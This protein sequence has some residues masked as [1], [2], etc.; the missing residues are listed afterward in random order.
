MGCQDPAV[1]KHSG[2]EQQETD[3]TVQTFVSRKERQCRLT[4]FLLLKRYETVLWSSN[5]PASRVR[6]CDTEILVPLIFLYAMRGLGVTGCYSVSIQLGEL[7]MEG[8]NFCGLDGFH[9]LGRPRTSE[10][11]N[12]LCWTGTGGC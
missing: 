2:V 8:G 11:G 10:A 6:N 4:S 7:A 9:R 12:G 5:Q 3:Q 1:D